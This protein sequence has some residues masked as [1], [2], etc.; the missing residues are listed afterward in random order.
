M[1]TS[2]RKPT[3]SYKTLFENTGTATILIEKDTT[4]SMQNNDL[5]I[6][7][8][9]DEIVGQS[10]MK[11]VADD[12]TQRLLEHHN[13]RRVDPDAAPQDYEFK[14][15]R[16]D[17]SFVHILMTIAMIPGTEPEHRFHDGYHEEI[18]CRD[19]PA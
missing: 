18:Q 10:W 14:I 17:G 6:G 11:F 16:K 1:S 9:K 2:S 5:N 3:N 7:Y 15:K 19:G 13:A 12:D 8:T 4:I